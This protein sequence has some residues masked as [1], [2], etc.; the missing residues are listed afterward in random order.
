MIF[1]KAV[2]R[3]GV[4]FP[5]TVLLLA[6]AMI[7][8]LI[9]APLR[10]TSQSLDNWTGGSFVDEAARSLTID[11]LAALPVDADG[12]KTLP[13]GQRIK[14]VLDVPIPPSN[15]KIADVHAPAKEE[16]FAPNSRSDRAAL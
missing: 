8:R 10:R 14:I 1:A 16:V 2:I 3:F 4:A 5:L 12:W 7:G 15:L 13:N 9:V 6:N 11:E